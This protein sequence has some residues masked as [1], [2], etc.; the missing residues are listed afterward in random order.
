MP[1]EF[2]A[3]F[4]FDTP[5]CQGDTVV[6]IPTF[7]SSRFTADVQW[8]VDGPEQFTSTL[9]TATFLFELPGTYQVTLTMQAQGCEEMATYEIEVG[10]PPFV[11]LGEDVQLCEN[12]SLS[13]ESNLSPDTYELLWQDGSQ[14]ADFLATGSGWVRLQASSSLGCIAT[15]S[16]LITA[17]AAPAFTLGQDVSICE[18]DIYTLMPNPSLSSV[19]YQ[20]ETGSNASFI[21]V[22]QTGTYALTVTDE[23]SGCQAADT[24]NIQA[25]PQPVFTF[26]PK[27][28][29]FC[30]GIPLVL[31]AI[32]ADPALEFTWAGNVTGSLFELLAAGTYTLQA[33]N[34]SCEASLNIVIPEGSCRA[35]M[36]LPNVFSPN[37]D[38][39]NDLFELMGPDVTPVKMQVY[40]R[41]G[42]L[43][44]EAEGSQ[45]SWDGTFN[46]QDAA[47]GLYVYRIEYL[48]LLSLETESVAGDLML[49]R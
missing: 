7:P 21:N 47:S 18:E 40:N 31:E 11:E 46:G 39:R 45:A 12:D 49:M 15:D 19:N 33:S 34:G 10:E 17:I 37:G 35:Q 1:S 2:S 5:I 25:I 41:W 24:V 48:N 13:I 28:T 29:S 14:E 8:A 42:S 27:D 38:G 9:D 22:S 4:T 6:F 3:D 43:V 36:Y 44:Y 32:T 30:P 16:L 26:Q 20:W 23:Q